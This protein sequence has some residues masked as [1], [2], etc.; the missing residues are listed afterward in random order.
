MAWTRNKKTKPAAVKKIGRYRTRKRP[1]PLNL[2]SIPAFI[3][4]FRIVLLAETEGLMR[5]SCCC[6]GWF[7]WIN[8]HTDAH[9][10]N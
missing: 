2:L 7:F 1:E 3:G 5:L 10:F 4:R 6:I 9:V 8:A